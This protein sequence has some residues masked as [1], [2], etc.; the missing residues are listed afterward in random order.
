MHKKL[1][2]SSFG[3]RRLSLLLLAAGIL[4]SA[5]SDEQQRSAKAPGQQGNPNTSMEAMPRLTVYKTPTCS[6]C[7]AWVEHVQ[8]GGFGTDV[9]EQETVA[10]IKDRF[11]IPSNARSC[12]TAVTDGGLVFEGHVPSR[13]IRQFIQQRPEGEVGL[14]VPAMPLGGPGM[15]VDDQFTPYTI[16]AMNDKGNLRPYARID[17]YQDQFQN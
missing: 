11:G 5:C 3:K 1:L 16:F 13:F 10:H 15:E 4:L 12:H 14:I 2:L 7:S 9:V 8:T 6:C 17:T